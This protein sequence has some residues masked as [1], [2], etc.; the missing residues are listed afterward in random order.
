MYICTKM[1][2]VFDWILWATHA[3]YLLVIVLQEYVYS[4]R[5]QKY[6]DFRVQNLEVHMNKKENVD[7]NEPIVSNVSNGSNRS[8]LSNEWNDSV[9]I[10]EIVEQTVNAC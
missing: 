2:T 10:K 4:Y 3:F 9:E 8:I 1:V 7:S 6:V 5:L